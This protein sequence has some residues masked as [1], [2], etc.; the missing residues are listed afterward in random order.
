MVG[1]DGGT[2]VTLI[3]TKFLEP[4]DHCNNKIVCQILSLKEHYRT[5]SRLL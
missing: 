1:I 4:G 2:T 3:V 5:I